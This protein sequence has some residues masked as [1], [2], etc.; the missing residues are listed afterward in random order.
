MIAHGGA[1]TI[2]HILAVLKTSSP[3]AIAISSILH[4][5]TYEKVSKSN[6][7][8]FEEGNLVFLKNARMFKNFNMTSITEIKKDLKKNKILTR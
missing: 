3:D 8:D 6:N 4:Y 5:S 7:Q 1:G 2:G